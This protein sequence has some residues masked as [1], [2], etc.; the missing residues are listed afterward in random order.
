MKKQKQTVAIARR[1]PAPPVHR[2]AQFEQLLEQLLG[3]FLAGRPNTVAAKRADLKAFAAWIGAEE[4]LTEAAR[5]LFEGGQ[6]G[7]NG[8]V[9]RWRQQLLEQEK[10]APATV[11]R[12]LASVRSL[13]KLGRLLGMVPW[14]LEVPNVRVER[15]RDTRGPGTDGVAR[16]LGQLELQG[17]SPRAARNAAIVHLLFDMALRRAEVVALDLEDLVLAGDRPTLQV[18]GKGRRQK[19][20][21]TVP[22]PTL[23]ALQRWVKVRGDRRG[24]LFCRLDN[25]ADG[26]G[27]RLTASGLYKMVCALGRA[28]GLRARPHGLRHAAVT[29]ALRATNGNLRAAQRYARHKNPQTTMVYDDALEDLAGQTAELVAKTTKEKT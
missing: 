16:L 15:Y 2:A 20:S 25:A 23:L 21:V 24:P 8:T 3:T 14:T 12:R 10:L 6:G 7:A 17:D 4:S 13:V 27:G 26:T 9:L 22:G 28:A 19:E 1:Q 11:N 18:L 29:E 5:V